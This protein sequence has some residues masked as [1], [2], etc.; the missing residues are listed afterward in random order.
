MRPRSIFRHVS[1]AEPDRQPGEAEDAACLPRNKPSAMPSGTG[2]KR[3]DGDSSAKETPALANPNVGMMRW[4]TKGSAHVQAGSIAL[5][6]FSG[7]IEGR[8]IGEYSA[9]KSSASADSA[10]FTIPR[11]AR[12]GWFRRTRASRST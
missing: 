12:S 10:S 6:S 4:A 8:P 1:K 3:A 11:I 5:K 2:S 9:A 7:G